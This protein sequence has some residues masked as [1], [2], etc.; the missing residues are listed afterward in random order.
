V[1]FEAFAV[2]DTGFAGERV[3]GSLVRGVFVGA[4]ATAGR[5]GDELHVDALR[6]YGFGGDADV[7][8]KALF[9]GEGLSCLKQAACGW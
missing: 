9:A 8:L 6:A 1:V 5:N 2:P 3:D 7:I 4:G